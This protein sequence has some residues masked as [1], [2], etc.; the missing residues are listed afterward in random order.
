MIKSLHIIYIFTCFQLL[1][2]KHVDDEAVEDMENKAEMN[3]TE[4][5]QV[6]LK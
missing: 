2:A 1:S 4:E 3:E 5:K 6:G